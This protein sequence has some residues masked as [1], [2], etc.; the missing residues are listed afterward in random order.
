MQTTKIGSAGVEVSRIGLGCV[1]FGREIDEIASFNVLDYAF[2]RGINLLDTAEAYGGGQAEAYR[3][4]RGLPESS[5]ATNEM[6]SS[7]KI[8]GRWLRS[9]GVRDKVVLQTKIA[10]NFTRSH[11][12]EALEASLERLQ[13]DYVDMYLFHSYDPGTPLEEAMEA[14]AAAVESG[15]VHAA[16]CSNFSIDQLRHAQQIAEER[17]LPHLE[18]IQPVYNLVRREIEKE[19]LPFCAAH[20]IAP[21]TYSPLRAG[22]LAGKYSPGGTFPKGS[23][24]DIIP[25]HANEYFSH[26]SFRTVES[27]KELS[28]RTGWPMVRLALAWA[29]HRS[30]IAG[31]LIGARHAGHV[32]NAI[33]ALDSPLSADIVAEM[34][35]FSGVQQE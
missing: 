3:K 21:V 26:Q 1:T 33:Q 6:H 30:S 19:V 27:L 8:I 12:Q 11:L 31:V 20:G 4:S 13:T 15:K 23:S 32:D 18:T 10:R 34:D 24:F 29:V 17:R 16:G 2:E 35:S 14:M 5:A 22:F 9:T 28:G 25:D 7:E